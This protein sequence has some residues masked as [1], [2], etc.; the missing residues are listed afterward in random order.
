MTNYLSAFADIEV[1]LPNMGVDAIK[2]RLED[3]MKGVTVS[4]PVYNPGMFLYRARKISLNFN[5]SGGIKKSDL[6]YPPS[7]LAK[8][9]RLNRDGQSIFYCSAHK[10]SIF[11]ELQGLAEGDEII[12]SFWKT[13]TKMIVNNIGYTEYVF[14]QLGAQRSIPQWDPLSAD[15]KQAIITLPRTPDDAFN[16]ILATDN[17]RILRETLSKYFMHSVKPNEV[18]RY[19]LTTAIGELHLGTIKNL[20][21]Q[22]AGV[23]YPS[24]RMSAN[25]DNLALLP[26]Y[27]DNHLEF[28]KAIHVRIDRR[29]DTSF[30]ITS[31]DTAKEFDADGTLVWL[32]RLPNWTLNKPGQAATFTFTAG[33][34]EDGDYEMSKDGVPCHWIAVDS[35]TGQVIERR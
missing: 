14:Q 22:F 11:F 18:D 17:N 27:V 24:V 3:F 7:H 29:T 26:W 20:D 6:V 32:G 10:Q 35:T 31:L 25:G 5:K 8:L 12:L 21:S 9:G 13:I 28:R 1:N 34:D 16:A 2:K 33:F 19:K 15:G 4:T 23:M 30:S